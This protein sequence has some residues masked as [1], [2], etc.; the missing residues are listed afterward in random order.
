MS[1]VAL[2]TFSGV[3]RKTKAHCSHGEDS[4]RRLLSVKFTKSFTLI[5]M[6]SLLHTRYAIRVLSGY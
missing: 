1:G 5:K 3:S 2:D 6:Q 4:Q